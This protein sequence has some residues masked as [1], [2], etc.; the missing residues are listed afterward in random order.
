MVMRAMRDSAKWVMLLL[1]IAF[2]GWLVF[3]W[4]QSRQSSA[5]TG[6][7][8]VVLT[9]N[10]QE[11]R[12]AQWTQLLEGRLDIA[13]SQ[14]DGRGGSENPGRGVG[15]HDLAGSARAGAEPSLDQD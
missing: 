9:V 14:A 8:P 7:N 2:V 11:I 3:D 12:L 6:P 1:S 15:D 4:V 13:R 10:G 5:A